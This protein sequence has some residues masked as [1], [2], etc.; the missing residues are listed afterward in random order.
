MG[1]ILSEEGVQADS[2]NLEAVENFPRPKTPNDVKSFLGFVG[3]YRR[4]ISQFGKTAK[5][6]TNLLQKG[7]EFIWD[8]KTEEAFKKL[9]GALITAPVL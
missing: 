4:Y 9:K 5:P 8:D 1:L 3:Y 2:K 7:K 6:L